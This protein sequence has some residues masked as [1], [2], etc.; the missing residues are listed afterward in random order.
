[1]VKHWKSPSTRLGTKSPYRILI[2]GALNERWS[3]WFNGIG[4]S[5]EHPEAHPPFTILT[6]PAIDQ[7]KL[8]GILNQ[9]W[10]LNLSLISLQQIPDPT[11]EVTSTDER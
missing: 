2:N 4:I 9:I 10:D 3:N 11:L 1:M 6:C 7:A 8:R 5:M